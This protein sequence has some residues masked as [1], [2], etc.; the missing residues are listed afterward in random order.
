MR[1][2][3]DFN[4]PAVGQLLNP[5]MN[6]ILVT[7]V[8]V[9]DDPYYGFRRDLGPAT[10]TKYKNAAW[11]AVR[12]LPLINGDKTLH[13]FR[14]VTKGCKEQLILKGLIEEYIDLRN[15]PNYMYVRMCAYRPQIV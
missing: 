8:A 9:N 15:R 10:S 5:E 6:N 7:V 3:P 2:Y 13:Q 4:W 11:V 12:L 14:G 1:L